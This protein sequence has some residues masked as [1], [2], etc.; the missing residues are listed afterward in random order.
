MWKHLFQETANID[1]HTFRH[2]ME[3]GH[4]GAGDFEGFFK[5]WCWTETNE[6]SRFTPNVLLN[7]KKKCSSRDSFSDVRTNITLSLA[8]RLGHVSLWHVSPHTMISFPVLSKVQSK[9]SLIISEKCYFSFQPI[10]SSFQ[11]SN[12]TIS[13][14]D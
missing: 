1:T 5:Q 13:Q 3:T 6:K 2:A 12:L 10:Y 8:F 9:K 11:N 7:Y 14:Y 4:V